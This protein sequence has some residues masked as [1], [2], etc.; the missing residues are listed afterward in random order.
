MYLVIVKSSGLVFIVL[1]LASIETPNGSVPTDVNCKSITCTL[2]VVIGKNATLLHDGTLPLPFQ[3]LI[4]SESKQ[5]STFVPS[6]LF[7]VSS[8]PDI[9]KAEA[10]FIAQLNFRITKLPSSWTVFF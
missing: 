10:L 8:E 6:C 1:I 3:I 5:I 4:F 7:I 2:S 9:E